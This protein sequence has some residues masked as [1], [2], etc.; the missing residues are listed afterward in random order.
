MLFSLHSGVLWVHP[1]ISAVV[2][3]RLQEHSSL[4][5]SI[6]LHYYCSAMY[7]SIAMYSLLWM[8]TPLFNL[9]IENVHRK[10]SGY[11][12]YAVWGKVRL[13]M[14]LWVWHDIGIPP[15]PKK[16][17]LSILNFFVQLS[18]PYTYVEYVHSGMFK[19]AVG[20]TWTSTSARCL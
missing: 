11:T 14:T 20:R 4:F 9:M 12:Q 8:T 1:S 7:I 6:P 18:L 16:Y 17:L 13:D 10:S 3:P 19:Q 2:G 15:P 5:I